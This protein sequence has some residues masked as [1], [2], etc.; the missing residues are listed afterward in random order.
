MNKRVVF[1]LF[2]VSQ[3]FGCSVVNLNGDTYDLT[4]LT[5]NA[6]DY[7]TVGKGGTYRVNVCRQLVTQCN[8]Q[9]PTASGCQ[10]TVPIGVV[11]SESFGAPKQTGE[12]GFGVLASYT[13]GQDKRNYDISFI[14]DW[15]AGVGSPVYSDESPT[16]Y[17]HLSWTT[18][19]ACPTNRKPPS[20]GI[21]GGKLSGG[22]II[23]IVLLVVVV[24]YFVGGI[25]FNKFKR[26]LSGV[27][28]IPNVAFWGSLPGLV[29]DGF[30]FLFGKCRGK[31]G[32]Q[33]V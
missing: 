30:K 25:L 24:I 9:S 22:S 16:L 3:I 33:T 11:T 19:F 10:N 2:L 28:V 13:G 4:P 18:K 12:Y 20:G 23:L 32:Y 15:N 1:C 29:R 8:S 14:C 27:E 21:G 7:S 5:N 17:Y 26:G 6:Q 31:S